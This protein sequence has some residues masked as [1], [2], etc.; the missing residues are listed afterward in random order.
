LQEVAEV[1]CV[2][3][4]LRR[5]RL[6]GRFAN[7]KIAKASAFRSDLNTPPQPSP[8]QE[9]ELIGIEFLFWDQI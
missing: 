9:R 1:P 8:S 7:H 6:G 5:G 3:L 2:L 4:P